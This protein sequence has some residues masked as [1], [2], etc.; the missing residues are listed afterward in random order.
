MASFIQ[1]FL[2]DQPTANVYFPFVFLSFLSCCIRILEGHPPG[3]KLVGAQGNN[4]NNNNSH[5]HHGRLALIKSKTVGSSHELNAKYDGYERVVVAATVHQQQQQ[6]HRPSPPSPLRSKV[7]TNW[8]LIPYMQQQQQQQ[9]ATRLPLMTI[10]SV[11]VC[12]CSSLTSQV[13]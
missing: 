4:T 5:L 11:C 8:H 6:P 1:I 12:V 7:K 10:H 2:Q 3:K 9:V 13:T